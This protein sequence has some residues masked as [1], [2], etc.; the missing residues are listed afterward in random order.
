[1]H[2]SPVLAPQPMQTPLGDSGGEFCYTW[3]NEKWKH[4]LF[5]ISISVLKEQQTQDRMS[6]ARE[7]DTTF[8]DPF[9][10]DM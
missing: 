5:N 9:H 6:L 8:T 4:Y 7:N 10:S 1:M 3:I 2:Q